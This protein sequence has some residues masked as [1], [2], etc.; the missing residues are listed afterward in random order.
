MKSSGTRYKTDNEKI[1][2]FSINKFIDGTID[3]RSSI[4]SQKSSIEALSNIANKTNN[5]A[6]FTCCVNS[7]GTNEFGLGI[8]K[9]APKTN[10]FSTADLVNPFNSGTNGRQGRR[11]TN[12]TS[13]T[14]NGLFNQPIID[15]PFYGGKQYFGCI[16]T[17]SFRNI[18][19]SSKTNSFNKIRK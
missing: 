9:L 14:T 13:N 5:L 17:D 2:G 10:I 6:F 15:R 12:S 8:S 18:S 4:S 16:M 1:M 19:I 3:K 7:D 11:L